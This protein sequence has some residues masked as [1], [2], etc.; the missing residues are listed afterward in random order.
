M[1]RRSYLA[2][3]GAALSALA[4]GCTADDGS[5]TTTTQTTRTSTVTD[6][7]KS[8]TVTVEAVR[9]QPA[10]VELQTDSLSVEDRGQ[11]VFADAA[12]EA[13]TADRDAYG[14]RV[15]GETHR[16]LTEPDTRQLWRV[17]GD[18]GY[19]PESGGVLA[20]ELPEAVDDSERAL[21]LE[22]PGGECEL[23]SAM[24]ARLTAG[25]PSLSWEV[26][27][28]DTVAVDESL[29]VAVAVHNAGDHP[30]RFVGAVSRYG[31]RVASTPVTGVTPLVDPGAERTLAV[32]QR[33]VPFGT[34]SEDVGD[35]E[36]DIRYTLQAASRSAEREVRVVE[37]E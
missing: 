19:A 28:P 12:V 16:P 6:R 4:A 13:G 27:V 11:Y 15:A 22:F 34:P 30:R 35:G 17:Y 10:A 2:A 1:R 31:P 26:S 25:S 24:V 7:A 20:F 9:V 32:N 37:R 21:V 8:P 5:P 23:G 33:D 29:A 3:T 36:V 14:L 18:D